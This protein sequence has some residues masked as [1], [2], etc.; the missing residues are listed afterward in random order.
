MWPSLM[1][2]NG[3]WA[4]LGPANHRNYDQLKGE[5][6]A[7]GG[8]E[9]HRGSSG[10]LW[11]LPPT[12]WSTWEAETCQLS[13]KSCLDA[14]RQEWV[15]SPQNPQFPPAATLKHPQGPLMSAFIQWSFFLASCCRLLSPHT[16]SVLHTDLW[17]PKPGDL[18]EGGNP[19]SHLEVVAQSADLYFCLPQCAY[20]HTSWRHFFLL[21]VG[22]SGTNKLS[23]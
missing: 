13:T 17:R 19:V 14:L 1:M 21:C 7:P 5:A 4:S 12:L 18:E 6:V 3:P 10:A 8:A 2:E 23:V 16:G 11:M 20:T 22:N 15:S 9:D